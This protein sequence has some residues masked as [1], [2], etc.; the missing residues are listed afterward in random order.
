[1]PFSSRLPPDE[2]VIVDGGS[3][4]QTVKSL[5]DHADRDDRLKIFI[6]PG[7]NIS[8]GR[9]IAIEN[10]TGSIIAVTDGGCRPDD[11]WLEELVQPLKEDSS[12]TAVGGTFKI[13]Y[14][15]S[16]EFFS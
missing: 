8:R 2:V 6:E 15:N 9:N 5:R 13:D 3:R 14:R 4:D 11:K 16:F 7:V 10:A 1:M 12:F